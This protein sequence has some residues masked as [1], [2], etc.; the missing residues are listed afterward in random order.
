MHT[1]KSRLSLIKNPHDMYVHNSLSNVAVHMACVNK[2]RA[3]HYQLE[4]VSNM[5]AYL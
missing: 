4:M 1:V 2:Y 5:R 3:R